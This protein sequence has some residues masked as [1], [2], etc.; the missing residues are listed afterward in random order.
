MNPNENRFDD[1][2]LAEEAPGMENRFPAN[3]YDGN[4]QLLC[5]S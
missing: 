4:I 3:S 2:K 5:Q 1:F